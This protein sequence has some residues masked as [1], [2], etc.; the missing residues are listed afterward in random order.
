MKKG[1][2]EIFTKLNADAFCLQET[3]LSEGQLSLDFEGYYSYWNYA[4]KKGYSGT[5]IF[6]KSKPLNVMMGIGEER[7]DQE[8]RC[9]TLEYDDHYLTTVY[10]PNSQDGLKRLAYRMGWEDSFFSYLE[11]LNLKKPVI[12]CGDMNVAHEPIDLKNDKTNHQNAGFTDEERSKMTRLLSS[13]FIDTYRLLYPDKE[14]YSWW[15]YRMK[16]RERNAGWRIDYF[17]ISDSLKSKL[18][19]AMIYTDIFGSD[20]APVGILIDL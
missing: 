2:N 9:I 11:S 17:L 10:A 14:E 15:S 20:H 4:L 1:F 6:T 3:K 8:G 18:K 13:G 12:V 19:E 7:H 16:A 5:A